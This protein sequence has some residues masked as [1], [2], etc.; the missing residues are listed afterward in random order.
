MLGFAVVLAISAASMGFAYLGFERVSA[1]VDAYRHSVQEADLARDIDRELISYRSLARYFVVT[2]KEEDGKAGAGGRSAPEGRHP[3]LDEGHH[4]PRAARAGRKAGAGIPHLHQDFRRHAQG[5]GG[6][7]AHRAEPARA[8]RQFAA[9]QARRPSEQCRGRRDAADHARRQEGDRAVS[10]GHRAREYLRGQLRPVGRHQRTGAP[11][12]RRERAEGDLDNQRKDPGRHQGNL[13]HAGRIP[14]VAR[15]AGRQCQGDRRS[16]PGN[17]GDGGRDQQGLGGD[18]VGSAGGSEA[19]RRRIERRHR[20]NRTADRDAGGGRLS[21]RLRLGVLPRQGHFP[22]DDQDVQRDARTCRRQFRCRAARPRPQRRTRRDGRRGRGVQ[23]AGRRAG[24]A[25]RRHPGSAEQ[26][27]E[28]R[29]PRRA[30]P[31]RR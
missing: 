14:P 15:H 29:A 12:I 1:G 2:G 25:R 24:R 16:D 30:D 20:R 3:G 27:G 10:G 7:R 8:H 17:D 23:D 4:R 6:E 9:L 22:A 31:V 5:Q 26:G 19:A 11:E 21:A 28:R 13:R 18:E